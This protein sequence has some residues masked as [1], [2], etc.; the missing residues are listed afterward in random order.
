MPIFAANL[1]A[2]NTSKPSYLFNQSEFTNEFTSNQ[3]LILPLCYDSEW[4]NKPIDDYLSNN[5]ISNRLHLSTQIKHIFEKPFCF[6]SEQAINATGYDF[7]LPAKSDFYVCDYLKQFG[8]ESYIEVEETENKFPT[9]DLYLY[10]F[11]GI[12]DIGLLAK[13]DTLFYNEIKN[14]LASK[15]IRHDKRINTDWNKPYSPHILFYIQ[16]INGE[17]HPYR[18]RLLFI[19]IC[20]MHGKAS[21][22]KVCQNVGIDTSAKSLMD[23]Y[24]SDMLTGLK[25]Y[26]DDYIRYAN[27]DLNVYDVLVAYAN[28]MKNVYNELGLSDYYSLPK[29]T[30]GATVAD[31]VSASVF[32]WQKKG[33]NEY[34]TKERKQILLDMLETSSASYLRTQ[35][36][37]SEIYLL[38]KVHGGRCR[39]NN[40][41]TRY[42]KDAIADYD[43][44]GAYSS[45]MMKLPFFTGNSWIYDGVK[46]SL[47]LREFLKRYEKEFDDWHYVFYVSTENN[48]L[49]C[50]QDFLVSWLD[51]HGDTEK[52]KING[53]WVKRPFADY[54]SG[55]CKVFKREVVNCPITSDTVKWIR[56]MSKKAQNDLFDKLIV[57][58]AIGYRRNEKDVNWHSINLGELLINQLKEKR[59]YYKKD[60]KTNP[61]HNSMQELY[62]LVINTVYGVQCSRH[63]ITSNVVVANQITQAIRLGVY[64]MEKGL[65]LQGAITDGCVGCLNTVLYPLS[66]YKINFDS[67]VNLYQYDKH[68]L[69]KNHLK[70]G[71]LDNAKHIALSWI[72]S[73]KYD[74]DRKR[75]HLAVLTIEYKDRMEVMKDELIYVENDV[76]ARNFICGNWIN[77]KAWQHLYKLFPEFHYLLDFLKIET[78]DVYDSYIYHGAANYRLQ[79][80]NYFKCAMRGYSGKKNIATGIEYKDNSIVANDYYKDKSIPDVFLSQLEFGKVKQNMP[81]ITDKILKSKEYVDRDYYKYSNLICGDNVVQ[82]GMP[83]YCSLSQ[84]TFQTANQYEQWL[85]IQTRLKNNYGESFEIFFTD[86]NGVLDYDLMVRTLCDMIDKGITNPIA[87]LSKLRYAKRNKINTRY[88]TKLKA[89]ELRNSLTFTIDESDESDDYEYISLKDE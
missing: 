61:I 35:L 23:N 87:H 57:K 79:N 27:G 55:Y 38:G 76:Y 42:V 83:N 63:F 54:N 62:K 14:G 40:P 78:K 74:K 64:L 9:L 67:L 43:L 41:L 58:S 3:S 60:A 56:S 66:D 31:I 20:A 10:S 18:L 75:I 24:K 73:G 71:A 49:E 32:N 12:V 52:V 8:I 51:L 68:N 30:I 47:S 19:D 44:A 29:L 26:P 81:F 33:V 4:N 37:K 36:N 21:Y 39:N 11:L 82:V 46:E 77:E 65:Y 6:F 72:D 25:L 84:Y 48:L 15:K 70:L 7:L 13:P 80:P 50:E 59:T 34:H 88:L 28:M 5:S 1:F 45:I 89:S 2:V 53:E 69:G 85:K 17:Y 22:K 86:K 16:D